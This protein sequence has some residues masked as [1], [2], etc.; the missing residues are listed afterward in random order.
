MILAIIGKVYWNPLNDIWMGKNNMIAKNLKKGLI[1]TLS[2]T[3]IFTLCFTVTSC[4]NDKKECESKGAVFIEASFECDFDKMEDLC[5]DDDALERTL[6]YYIFEA[7]HS[8]DEFYLFEKMLETATF[9]VVGVENVRDSRIAVTYVITVCSPDINRIASDNYDSINDDS[10]I[11]DA[12]VIGIEEAT[13]TVEY[14]VELEF[15]NRD[16]IWLIANPDDFDVQFYGRVYHV[17]G[18]IEYEVSS[19]LYRIYEESN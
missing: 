4:K 11:Y 2:M 17:A 6:E 10:D 16:G 13:E 9:D 12:C 3:L 7:E 15:V 14:E 1:N 18:S 8:E 19:E 5:A